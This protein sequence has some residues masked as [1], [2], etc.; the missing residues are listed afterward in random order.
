MVSPSLSGGAPSPQGRP[1]L[2]ALL[3]GIDEA[4]AE[5][6]L[7]SSKGSAPQL[8]S[9]ITGLLLSLRYDPVAVLELVDKLWPYRLHPR[10]G[11]G[12]RQEDP[13]PLV[14]YL[15]PFCD[16]VHGGVINLANIYRRLK[17]DKEYRRMCGYVD[18]LP[19]RSVLQKTSTVMVR[20]WSRF[21][22]CFLSPEDYEKVRR[23][24]SRSLDGL[25]VRSSSGLD[26]SML[27]DELQGRGW[28]DGLPPLYR[29]EER[30]FSMLHPVGLPHLEVC[31][32]PSRDISVGVDVE[33]PTLVEVGKQKS[34]S[35]RYP[36]DWRAY[37]LAQTHE[38][39]DVKALLGGFCEII[40]YMENLLLGPRG[41]GRPRWSLGHVVF[42]L[43]WK[44]YRCISSRR[45]Q[46]PLR[47]AAM[48]G[49][50]GNSSLSS[51]SRGNGVVLDSPAGESE[52]LKFNTVSESMRSD[53]LMPLLLELVS[54]VAAPLR[55]LETVFALDSTGLST[56]IFGRWLDDK[57]KKDSDEE[58]SDGDEGGDA[59]SEARDEDGHTEGEVQDENGDERHDWMKLHA[60]FG[61]KTV[62][63]VRAA[64]SSSRGGDTSF[65]R[66]L[67]TEARARFNVQRVTADKAYSSWDN[68]EL[69]EELGIW[70]LAPYKDNTRTPSDD[71]D[72]P[73][74]RG[75]RYQ[76]G[77]PEG[78]WPNYFARNLSESGFSAIKRLF[79]APLLSKSYSGLVNEGLCR[80]IA[81]N[82]IVLAR[83]VRMRGI[84]LDL[85]GVA[86][87]LEDSIRDVIEMR[88]ARCLRLP[89]AA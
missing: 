42:A 83:E 26:L 61:T 22:E 60:L 52:Y 78:F 14:C 7:A 8:P 72:S 44:V 70:F 18:R 38:E 81:Y 1:G 62:A 75:Y 55:D 28:T 65:F 34:S 5:S 86:M 47:E 43:V 85:P 21:Q 64:M 51:L 56:R 19:S 10:S 76:L 3:G 24:T 33:V 12:R 11:P 53:W 41:K 59:G 30:F 31:E 32:F 49:Y 71:D 88:N 15:L 4:K 74:A 79:A 66:G 20:N 57:P 77:C 80:V 54:V 48:Q 67:T 36:R 68:A 2:L 63:I 46:S 87:L 39:S 50:L 16:A 6:L 40:T 58:T 35:G 25:S 27:S 89:L 73:W 13:L 23:R 9:P 17:A 29:F 37:N 82:L 69:A 45:S 84:E